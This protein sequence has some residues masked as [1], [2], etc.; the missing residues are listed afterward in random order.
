MGMKSG[1]NVNII[2]IVD[3]MGLTE[4][5]LNYGIGETSMTA[6]EMLKLARERKRP[7]HAVFRASFPMEFLRAF[8]RRSMKSTSGVFLLLS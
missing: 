8:Y 2:E 6:G 5:P 1:G 4:H 3:E 7:I